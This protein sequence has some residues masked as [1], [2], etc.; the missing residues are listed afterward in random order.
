[1]TD[2][3]R[4]RFAKPGG[5]LPQPSRKACREILAKEGL[6]HL[7]VDSRIPKVALP[8]GVG[9]T[10]RQALKRLMRWPG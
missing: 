1:V 7:D 3:L 8:S 9:A 10:A 4:I 5:Y 2:W 6:G